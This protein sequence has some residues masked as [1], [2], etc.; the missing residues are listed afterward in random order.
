MK[1]WLVVLRAIGGLL[2]SASAVA[3]AYQSSKH[4]RRR[5]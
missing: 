3:A 1:F 5:Y 2:I 4:D